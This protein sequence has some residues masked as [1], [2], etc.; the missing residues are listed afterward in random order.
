M[1]LET[2]LERTVK[3]NDFPYVKQAIKEWL[4]QKRQ[5]TKNDTKKYMSFSRQGAI[6]L[7]NELLEETE[8]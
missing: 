6:Q 4:L 5:E 2:Y 1:S 8:K 7:I 3:S